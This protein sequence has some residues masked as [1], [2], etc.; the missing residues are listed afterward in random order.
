MRRHAILVSS[1]FLALAL[2]S[3]LAV[4][5][6]RNKDFHK[7]RHLEEVKG[8][9][10]EAI[11][12][13]KQ[14]LSNAADEAL[15]AQAQ[16]HIGM[17]YEK[18]GKQEARKAYQ[19]VIDNYPI[20]QDAVRV[21]RKRL[22]KLS[23]PR[24]YASADKGSTMAARR[25]W[26][27]P[28]VD[29]SGTITLDGRYLSFVDWGTGGI[30]VRDLTTGEN[31]RLT[32]KT[33]EENPAEYSWGST[34]SRDGKQ[35]AYNW[36]NWQTKDLPFIDLR[37]TS[38][39]RE[40][41]ASKP[42]ILYR[43]AE[44][45]TIQPSDWSPDG[46]HVLAIFTRND[47][48][49]LIA[50]VSVADRSVQTLKTLD[51]R[52]PVQMSFSPDGQYIVYDFPTKEDAPE[53][54]IFV[55]A[56]DGSREI[57]LVEHPAND[58]VLGWAPDGKRVL[59]ASDRTG[60]TDAWVIPVADGRPQDSPQLVKTGIG[61]VLPLGFT[62]NGSF[63]Y[64]VGRGT[65][66]VY[67]AT[68]DPVTGQVLDPPKKISQR[69]V[70]SNLGPDWSPD[71]RYLAYLSLRDPA[72]TPGF[73]TAGWVLVIRSVETGEERELPLKMTTKRFVPRWSPDGRSLLAAA[74]DHKGRMGVYRIDAQTG[75][76][77][78]IVQLGPDASTGWAEWSPDGKAIFYKTWDFATRVRRILERDL[79]TGHE[80]EL[81]R[82][83]F[84][85]ERGGR[86]ISPDGRQWVLV[87][88]RN[89]LKVIPATG[90]EPRE[91][92]RLQ[93]REQEKGIEIRGVAW[94]PDG[95]H[96][97]FSKGIWG[98]HPKMELWRISAEGGEPQK[99][100]LAMGALGMRN[101]S[102]HPDGRRIAFGASSGDET[103]EVWVM[104]NFLPQG[105]GSE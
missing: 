4:S 97:L 47:R 2:M 103:A 89:V 57:A 95:R 38:V 69:Y 73:D 8:E 41:H 91:L 67:I 33:W 10:E 105:K 61:T 100:G 9:L 17:C 32:N 96:L 20:Q 49:N 86:A 24:K 99:L 80:R 40:G 43:N 85:S 53:R 62:R 98:R 87:G 72:P 46:K 15:A 19:A 7:A 75:E 74:R 63:Y 68:L 56:A 23:S 102:V 39:A 27:G 29:D 31:R 83:T 44:V 92:L 6:A 55:L 71:G 1:V 60:S 64:G 48:T 70:G 35:V 84:G 14:V 54:D 22:A 90:G 42:R 34:I 11:V 81:D 65:H 58:W 76:V 12:L 21:A 77:L 50:L 45:Y 5:R 93:Q 52:L 3:D 28:G 37:V 94:M 66:D 82:S 51:W 36:V 101:L 59:F 26:A 104:E 25:V 13:Y 16:L 88:N 30:A 79:E 78:P 18:L